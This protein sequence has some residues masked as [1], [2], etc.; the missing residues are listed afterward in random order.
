MSRN[1]RS[2]DA[3]PR[4]MR[5]ETAARYCDEVSV[6]KFLKDVGVVWPKPVNVKGG[7][8]RWIRDHLDLAIDQ[9]SNEPTNRMD[10]ADVF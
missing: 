5:V 9:L 10:L 6:E 1:F 8:E 7:G 3:W 4:L 2:I